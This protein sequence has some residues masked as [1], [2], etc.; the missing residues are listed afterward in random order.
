M[1]STLLLAILLAPQEDERLRGAVLGL[2]GVH[3]EPA[4]VAPKPEVKGPARQDT[5]KSPRVK[6][7][8]DDYKA[9]LENNVFSAPR[10]KDPPKE[11]K[12]DGGNSGPPLPKTRKWTLTGVVFN[13]VD[14]RYE[15]LIED[16]SAKEGRYLKSGDAIAGVTI[17][18]VTLDQVSYQKADGTGVLKIQESLT[19]VI[20]GTAG[21]GSTESSK[22]EEPADAD[23]IR[24]R[25]KKRHKRESVPDEA[26]EDAGTP[27]KP[28]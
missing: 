25:M 15:A 21:T 9:L 7:T 27:K 17:S 5:F 12:P 19:E 23:K 28:K 13:A 16:T 2:P 1:I 18:E 8:V 14:K 22:V 3:E 4:A 6:R 11:V 24:E 26:E 10:K 20:S